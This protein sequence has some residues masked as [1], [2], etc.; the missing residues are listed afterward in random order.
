MTARGDVR[1]RIGGAAVD[2][3]NLNSTITRGLTRIGQLLYS[4]VNFAS[5]LRETS[6]VIP[7]AGRTAVTTLNA[8]TYNALPEDHIIHVTY[9]S[10]GAVTNLALPTAQVTKGRMIVIKDAG[11]NA[12]TNNIT[13]TTEGA[14]TIDGAATL[15][16]ASNYG[17]A[18]LYCDGNNWFTI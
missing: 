1:D 5:Y 2:E 8:A 10:T 6:R 4:R 12:G 3:A 9:T 17:V 15:V 18:R 14:E 13:I 16:I 11:G 7:I